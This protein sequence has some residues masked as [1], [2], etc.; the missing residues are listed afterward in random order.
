MQA[1]PS[2]VGTGTVVAAA[3]S[4]LVFG[5]PSDSTLPASSQ[6]Q[7][8]PSS[9]L[10]RKVFTDFSVDSSSRATPTPPPAS[11]PGTSPA[12]SLSQLGDGH[13]G[14]THDHHHCAPLYSH[15]LSGNGQP[16]SAG[17]QVTPPKAPSRRQSYI[18]AAEVAP[19]INESSRD[20]FQ[21]HQS[22]SWIR[23]LSLRP[24]SQQ[25]SPRSSLGPDS[26][27]SFSQASGSVVLS[28]TVSLTPTVPPNK[29]IKR[30]GSTHESLFARRQ[31]KGEI[32]TLRRPAT[33]HQRSATVQQLPASPDTDMPFDN[34]SLDQVSRP[35]AST[36][37]QTHAPLRLQEPSNWTSFFHMRRVKTARRANVKSP[38]AESSL[39]DY[40]LPKMRIR[41]RHGSFPR[42]FLVKP[43]S[44]SDATFEVAMAE[45]ELDRPFTMETSGRSELSARDSD[46]VLSEQSDSTSTRK[47][48]RS[49]STQF[50][51]ATAGSLRR[52]KRK[53]DESSATRRY[54]SDPTSSSTSDA[55]RSG[56]RGAGI[57]ELFTPPK[58]A[59]RA[60]QSVEM[61][62]SHEQTRD[63]SSPIPPLSRLSTFHMDMSRMGPSP[64]PS[65][66]LLTSSPT[67]FSPTAAPF[68]APVSLHSRAVSKEGA[69]TL[70]GSEMSV[71]GLA[72]GDDDTDYRSDALFDS[73][74]TT[75]TN[76]LRMVET[77]LDTM[78]DESF[79]GAP[80]NVKTKR[81]SIQ[82]ILGNSW[83][84]NTRILEE[85]EGGSTPLRGLRGL[86]IADDTYDAEDRATEIAKYQLSMGDRGMGTGRLS[87]DTTDDDYD[88]ARDDEE[89]F[90]N[91][92]SPPVTSLNLRRGP[93]LLPLRSA[94]SRISDKSTSDGYTVASPSERP[95]SNVFDWS[96]PSQE[97]TDDGVSRPRTAH[98]KQE[99]DPRGGRA[100]NRK[101]CAPAHI[102]S[103]SVP[104]V[105]DALETTKNAPKFG[106]WAVG[107]KNASEEWDDDFDFD[108]ASHSGSSSRPA[109]GL[110][111]RVPESIRAT[112][113]TVKAHS[114]QIRELSLLV[115]SLKRL[116]RQG[117]E[118]NLTGGQAASLWKEA[119]NIISLASPDEDEAEETDTDRSFSDFDPLTIDERFLDEGFDAST[120]DRSEGSTHSTDPDIPKN[121][122]VKEKKVARRRSVFSPDDDIFGNNSSLELPAP[123]TRPHTPRTP[124]R[125]REFH[126]PDGTVVSS[127]I[128]AMEQQRSQ[129]NRPPE[130]PLKPST[131]KLFFDTNSLQELVKRANSIFHTLSDIVRREELLTM[132][133]QATP[134]HDRHRRGGSPAFTRVFSGPDEGSPRHLVKSQKSHSP[135]PRSSLESNGLSQ[136]M[137]M[138]TVS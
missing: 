79:P 96:E 100:S 121:A 52:T 38:S 54:A 89:A 25:D 60:N 88:W 137:Q 58:S 138:M 106:T 83:D 115:S 40:P 126:T 43:Q 17:K 101:G 33:S 98:G 49:L 109:K 50:R 94:L 108:E 44:I 112:Q 82:E 134:R 130:S 19:S 92:L 62:R 80:G 76:R 48:R 3:S 20:S 107:N 11:R 18:R 67:Q 97:K 28:P 119:E 135:M 63:C 7:S 117:R 120:L 71:P 24:S 70:A 133:P 36:T 5:Q 93:S 46:Q 59:H 73:F 124:E 41:V 78:F 66:G 51:K 16:A 9:P 111:M 39:L 74:R 56:D 129:P 32:P 84:G 91:P 47:A 10:V 64:P 37:G 34:M 90:S 8:R 103:Q 13:S 136:R 118:L 12:V 114:G 104:V 131:A 127:V 14:P 85:D 110:L 2:L 132:S 61:S 95:R 75:D 86:R 6:R 4:G 30:F 1:V 57:H 116:C 102:R 128:A 21:S 45:S 65:A 105:H 122:V 53:T 26:S 42:P 72:S 35:R 23:R 29:L 81:L 27:I 125:V 15:P 123:A 69:S 31:S 22:S 55:A 87:L 113:P 68:G 99:S 77:P